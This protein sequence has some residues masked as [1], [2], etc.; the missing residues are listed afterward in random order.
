M[1]YLITEER[2]EGAIDEFL[3]RSFPEVIVVSFKTKSVM[4]GSRDNEI[5]QRKVI[6]VTMDPHNIITGGKAVNYTNI[7]NLKKSIRDGLDAMFG[8]GLNEYGSKWG[9][10]VYSITRVE[11]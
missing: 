7:L 11:V 1:K 10:V 6:Q 2:M 8:L 9:V 4:L 5:I 3:K